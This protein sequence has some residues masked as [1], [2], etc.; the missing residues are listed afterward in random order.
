MADI[1]SITFQKDAQSTYEHMLSILKTVGAE[2]TFQT[3][4][5]SIGFS[6]SKSS[7]GFKYGCEGELTIAPLPDGKT[8]VVVR[9]RSTSTT[10]AYTLGSTAII[11][12]VLWFLFRLALGTEGAIWGV[13]VAVAAGVGLFWQYSANFPGKTL[14][15]IKQAAA[16]VVS[17]SS[18]EPKDAASPASTKFCNHCGQKIPAQASFCQHCGHKQ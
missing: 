1:G 5:S 13:I 6:V 3:P 14:N 11:G 16:Q 12:V 8:N 7:G 15:Q 4:P 18:G 9:V 17:T 10:L 2:A